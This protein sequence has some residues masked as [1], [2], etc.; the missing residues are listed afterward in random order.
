MS[1]HHDVISISKSYHDTVEFYIHNFWK[2]LAVTLIPSLLTA[3][4]FFSFTIST[5][6]ALYQ[7]PLAGSLFSS[8]NGGDGI[9]EQWL[10]TGGILLTILVVDT[11]GLIALILSVTREG[12]EHILRSFENSLVYFWRFIGL[13][14]LLFMVSVVGLFVGFAL[15]AVIGIIL[16]AFSLDLVDAVFFWTD[17]IIPSLVASAFTVFFIFAKFIMI[18]DNTSLGAAL[19]QSVRLVRGHFWPVAIR[20]MLAYVVASTLALG[21]YLLPQVGSFLALAVVTPLPF[22]Y[23]WV[24]YRDLKA[25]KS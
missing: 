25:L 16:G 8:F 4:L 5:F 9:N 6:S 12:R 15:V 7:L 17:T 23:L 14:V 13:G 10:I 3:A 21:I 1:V 22:I 2:L 24:L 11:L 20:V 18:E 19:L